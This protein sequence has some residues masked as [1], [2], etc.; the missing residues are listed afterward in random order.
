MIEKLRGTVDAVFEK[1][2]TLSVHGVGFSLS[3]PDASSLKPS[4]EVTLFTYLHW[5]QDKGPV[6]YGFTNELDRTV[7]LLIIECPKIGPS[8]ATTILGNISAA[9]FLDAVASQNE[10]ALSSVNGIGVKK[11]EQL[12]TSLKHKVSKLI[13]QGKLKTEDQQSFAHWHQV[14]QVLTSLNYS[15]QEITSAMQ[16]L[17]EK[18]TGKEYPLDQLIRATLTFLSKGL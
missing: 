15:R 1:S 4:E 12:V 3:V 8:I 16:Y 7:F 5:H 6:L 10:K 13:S 18:Y 14:S 2:V 17:S 9:Q 11:A